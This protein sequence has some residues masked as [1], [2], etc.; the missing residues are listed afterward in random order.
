MLFVELLLRRVR[1]L[2]RKV[3]FRCLCLRNTLRTS[4]MWIPAFL[5]IEMGC[6][7]FVISA[8]K[9]DIFYETTKLF[10]IYL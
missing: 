7:T 1:L 9:I 8:A 6:I 4:A 10:C 5:T 2:L 3:R